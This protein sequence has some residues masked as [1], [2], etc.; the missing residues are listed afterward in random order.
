M[1]FWLSTINGLLKLHAYF[2][3][4]RHA[5]AYGL[6]DLN[7]STDRLRR[8]HVLSWLNSHAIQQGFDSAKV[9]T[10][11]NKV[12]LSAVWLSDF[13]FFRKMFYSTYLN[14]IILHFM[15]SLSLASFKASDNIINRSFL[16]LE[17]AYKWCENKAKKTIKQ[18]CWIISLD[19]T[20]KSILPNY[21][22][23]SWARPSVAAIPALIRF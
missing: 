12:W 6:I 3:L 16:S 4:A 20:V 15:L 7:G 5:C 21:R 22:N 23:L 14:V 1:S 10:C 19:I 17:M 2:V 18:Q 13:A 9:I 8:C 11:W